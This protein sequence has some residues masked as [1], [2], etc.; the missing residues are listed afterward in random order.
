MARQERSRAPQGAAAAQ[1]AG[2]FFCREADLQ[3]LEWHRR[4][5]PARVLQLWGAAGGGKKHLARRWTEGSG[6]C[7]ACGP[8]LASTVRRP[9]FGEGFGGRPSDAGE[10]ARLIVARAVE[11]PVALMEAELLLANEPAFSRALAGAWLARRGE[12]PCLALGGECP[13]LPEGLPGGCLHPYRVQPVSFQAFRRRLQGLTP[14]EQLYGYAVFGG[15]P[16]FFLH[17]HPG[18]PVADSV[19]GVLAHPERILPAQGPWWERRT[20]PGTAL[21]VLAGLQRGALTGA[22]LRLCLREPEAGGDVQRTLAELAR[23]DLVLREA[24]LCRKE[25]GP[26][27]AECWELV[28][29]ALRFWLAV[30]GALGREPGEPLALSRAEAAFLCQSLPGL[31]QGFGMPA[32]RDACFQW[33][34]QVNA[35]GLL[36]RN[37]VRFGLWIRAAQG[38]PGKAQIPG[39]RLAFVMETEDGSHVLACDCSLRPGGE[40]RAFVESLPARL[41]RDVPGYRDCDI[42][43]AAFSLHGFSPDARRR[44]RELARQMDTCFFLAGPGDVAWDPAGLGGGRQEEGDEG[45]APAQNGFAGAGFRDLFRPEEDVL[46]R[47]CASPVLQ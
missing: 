18:R 8:D 2:G 29:G 1:D 25:A 43:Y 26:V 47:D 11:G 46:F 38:G 3:A 16:H 6:V 42:R 10:A 4:H 45:P 36:P 5:G 34:W 23:A 20:S 37:Y 12:R 28:P 13:P 41:G 44:A 14:A 17:L 19:Y 32:F 30:H 24:N 35:C 15:Q 9:A 39:E 33:L 40:G 21:E 31:V 27:Q 7:L 22:E